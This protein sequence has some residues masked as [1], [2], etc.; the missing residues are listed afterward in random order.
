M[1]STACYL[2]KSLANTI[3]HSNRAKTFRVSTREIN[4]FIDA[5]SNSQY[6]YFQFYNTPYRFL[7]T[8]ELRD[9]DL[10]ALDFAS[11]SN[12]S[13]KYN[14]YHFKDTEDEKRRAYHQ[15]D[16]KDTII[17]TDVMSRH[18]RDMQVS[19]NSFYDV[20]LKEI[21]FESSRSSDST[22][23]ISAPSLLEKLAGVTK[24]EMIYTLEKN[25]L[26]YESLAKCN[27]NASRD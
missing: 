25:R 16:V 27:V 5:R 26:K 2:G 14:T 4:R 13:D 15:E 10:L 17:G 8:G 18:F 20:E 19:T 1:S 23:R 12:I 6:E 7:D 9:D 24:A 3:N 22:L 21:E 11:T